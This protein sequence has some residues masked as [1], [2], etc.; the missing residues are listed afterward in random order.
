MTAGIVFDLDGTLLDTPRAIVQAFTASLSAM[1]IQPPAG[2]AIRA[3][4][5]LPLEVAFAGLLSISPEDPRIAEC[6][7]Q[8]QH[9]FKELILPTA[10]QLIFP[11]VLAGLATL[12]AEGFLLAVATSKFHASAVAILDAAGLGGKFDLVVGAD[13]VSKPKPDPEMGLHVLAELGLAADHAVMVGDTTHD[14]FMATAVG[15]GSIA[16]T[17]GI[18]GVPELLSAQ[19][20]WILD[21]FDE[22]VTCI[23]VNYGNVQLSQQEIVR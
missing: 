10:R 20:S 14:V 21:T 22:V 7:R 19:P 4:I 5:G 3:T 2:P 18:H 1:G 6:I 11:G 15:I 8:Y 23:Q 12:R 9:F 16:V 13:Q 17:Y